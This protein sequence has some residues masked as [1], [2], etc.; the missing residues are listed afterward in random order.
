MN[1]MILNPS[2]EITN[3]SDEYIAIPLGK[4]VKSFNGI[5]ALNEASA[6]LLQKMDTPKSMDELSRLLT[7][8]YDVDSISARKDIED[9][10]NKVSGTGLIISK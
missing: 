7:E 10:F 1:R 8:E 6:F 9:F 5:I 3:I 2:F 4:A